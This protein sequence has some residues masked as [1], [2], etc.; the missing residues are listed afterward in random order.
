MK[1]NNYSSSINI[2]AIAAEL[3]KSINVSFNPSSLIKFTPL[4]VIEIYLFNLSPSLIKIPI[5]PYSAFFFVN[6]SKASSCIFLF[7]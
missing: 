5:F 1:K 2:N 7:E 4:F 6:N 3:C